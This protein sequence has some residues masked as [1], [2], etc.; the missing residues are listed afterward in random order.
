MTA[1]AMLAAAILL[2]GQVDAQKPP[3]EADAEI[4]IAEKK[5]DD[6]GVKKGKKGKGEHK[7]WAMSKQEYDCDSVESCGV[8]KDPPYYYDWTYKP[9]SM[10][11]ITKLHFI[12]GDL[13]AFI[14]GAEIFQFWIKTKG[15]KDPT[16]DQW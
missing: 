2:A 4:T 5:E 1:A 16:Y 8:V 3:K 15:G 10:Y 9:G 12:Q 7:E 6:K 11:T 13:L 14:Y